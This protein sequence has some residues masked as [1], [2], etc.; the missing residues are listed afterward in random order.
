[1]NASNL[2]K[3][4][5]SNCVRVGM[6]AIASILNKNHYLFKQGIGL[7]LLDHLGH[8]DAIRRDD[9]VANENGSAH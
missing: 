9:Q 8:T 7:F 6:C 5:S 3:N 2:Q 4:G 1:M